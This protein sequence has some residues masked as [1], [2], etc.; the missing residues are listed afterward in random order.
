M[1]PCSE[2]YSVD[3]SSGDE[4]FISDDSNRFG[5]VSCTVLH[6][7]FMSTISVVICGSHRIKAGHSCMAIK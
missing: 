3:L 5:P 2:E 6:S 4:H 1:S 7:S